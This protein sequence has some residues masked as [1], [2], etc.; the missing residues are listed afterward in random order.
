[1]KKGL[2][3]VA[4]DT[5]MAIAAKMTKPPIMSV[6]SIFVNMASGTILSLIVSIFIKK[7]GNP[8]VDTPEY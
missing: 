6:F 7:E 3:E 2:P 8:L 4:I 5:G 1:M